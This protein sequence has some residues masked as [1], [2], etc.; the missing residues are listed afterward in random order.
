[1]KVQSKSDVSSQVNAKQDSQ[2]ESQTSASTDYFSEMYASLSA[3]TSDEISTDAASTETTESNQDV[4]QIQDPANS[5]I[6]GMNP[7]LYDQSRAADQN[8][9]VKIVNEV[10][11]DLPTNNIDQQQNKKPQTVADV[12]TNMLLNNQPEKLPAMKVD[13]ISLMQEIEK[14]TGFNLNDEINTA[15]LPDEMSKKFDKNNIDEND[16]EVKQL[17]V[18]MQRSTQHDDKL[19]NDNQ[20]VTLY[21]TKLGLTTTSGNAKNNYVDALVQMSNVINQQ[22]APLAENLQTTQASKAPTYSEILNKVERPEYELKIDLFPTSLNVQEKNIYQAHIKIYPPELGSVRAELK[23]DKN[24]AEL[25]I[26]AENEKVKQIIEANLSQLKESFAQS[27]IN[28]T[29]IHVNVQTASSD[30]KDQH[31]QQGRA[32]HL[33]EDNQQSTEMNK[34]KATSAPLKKRLD[35]IVDTYA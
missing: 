23:V 18:L 1:M 2:T 11:Q 14:I 27:N 15:L 4:E 32:N 12:K 35:A 13:N 22:T 24:N 17:Q 8:N 28:L 5:L 29:N 31:N 7:L 30:G 9:D 26:V 19:S 21:S 34:H 6:Y 16:N 25:V 33:S 3:D 10:E 20:V